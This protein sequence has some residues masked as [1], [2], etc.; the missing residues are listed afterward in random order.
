MLRRGTEIENHM[1]AHYFFLKT[2]VCSICRDRWEHNHG[3]VTNANAYIH[4]RTIT[5]M[6]ARMHVLSL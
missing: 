4:E 5:S 1:H 3:P 2:L 6:N